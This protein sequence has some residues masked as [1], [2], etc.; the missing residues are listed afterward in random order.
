MAVRAE[1]IR[2]A[3]RRPGLARCLTDRDWRGDAAANED[4]SILGFKVS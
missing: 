4:V 1:E 3:G 2:I